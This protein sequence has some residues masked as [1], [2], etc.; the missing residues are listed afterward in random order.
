MEVT[1]KPESPEDLAFLQRLYVWTHWHDLD[2]LKWSNERKAA[3]LLQQ[4]GQQMAHFT[5]NHANGS[6]WVIWQGDTPIGR[7]YID[8][9]PSEIRL[10]ALGLLP[11]FRGRGVGTQLL[12]DLGAK[13]RGSN[14]KIIARVEV[15]SPAVGWFE[16]KGF[17]Q[18]TRHGQ[19]CAM[20]LP[21][22]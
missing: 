3:Y 2:L 17:H 6:Y 15:T 16:R 22:Y 18:F 8:D 21:P 12:A 4:F 1:L 20:E 10:L 19:F 13:A 7:Y 5:E 9:A 11:D 14:R